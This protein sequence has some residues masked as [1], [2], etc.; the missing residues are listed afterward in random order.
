VLGTICEQHNAML[1]EFLPKAVGLGVRWFIGSNENVYRVDNNGSSKV[2]TYDTTSLSISLGS[3]GQRLWSLGGDKNV[4]TYIDEAWST[5][6]KGV[7]RF[8]A[9]Q[10]PG[11]DL[12]NYVRV[13][14]VNLTQRVWNENAEGGPAF[15]GTGVTTQLDVSAYRLLATGG[16]AVYLIDQQRQLW[17][18]DPGGDAGLVQLATPSSSPD[19]ITADGECLYIY[20]GAE[21]WSRLRTGLQDDG[22]PWVPVTAPAASA[23]GLGDDWSYADVY[24]DHDGVLTAVIAKGMKMFAYVDGAWQATDGN[25]AKQVVTYPVHGWREFL[26]LAEL[27]RAV[28]SVKNGWTGD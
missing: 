7:D 21:M 8:S 17:V 23:L 4:Y 12:T 28:D 5:A 27:I 10:Q 2:G 11:T 16:S 15:E 26:G 22:V 3:D 24:S 25:T 6:D 20:D 14:G 9:A 13:Q 19:G 1:K 18:F